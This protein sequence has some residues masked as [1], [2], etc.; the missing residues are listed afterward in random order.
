MRARHVLYRPCSD[1]ARRPARRGGGQ[2][3]VLGTCGGARP[4]RPHGLPAVSVGARARLV[5]ASRLWR[6]ALIRSII[7]ECPRTGHSQVRGSRAMAF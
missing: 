3:K 1:P 5:S 7:R 6:A 2:R 4:S